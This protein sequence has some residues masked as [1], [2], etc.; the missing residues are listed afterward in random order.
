MKQPHKAQCTYQALD[1]GSVQDQNRRNEILQRFLVLNVLTL[2]LDDRVSLI[3]DFDDSLV[4]G[5]MGWV[6]RFVDPAIYA[7]ELDV[8]GMGEIAGM[9]KLYPVVE[10]LASHGVKR[11]SLVLPEVW[12]VELPNGEVLASRCQVGPSWFL[13][14]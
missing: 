12:K 5:S 6:I 8:D 7:T 4:S 10:F 14:R 11:K 13:S 2:R 3:Q 9:T 1:G